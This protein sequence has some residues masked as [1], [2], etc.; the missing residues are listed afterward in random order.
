MEKFPFR[1]YLFSL[2]ILP[3]DLVLLKKTLF[4][5]PNLGKR[6]KGHWKMEIAIRRMLSLFKLRGDVNTCR[7][8]LD[9]VTQCPS[10]TKLGATD[11]KKTVLD[12]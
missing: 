3:S 11:I 9:F 10:K 5:E 2:V 8:C 1:S 7:K 12:V 4:W 6:R